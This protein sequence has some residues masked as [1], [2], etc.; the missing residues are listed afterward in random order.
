MMKTAL[1]LCYSM[2]RASIPCGRPSWIY[3]RAAALSMSL[4]LAKSVWTMSTKSGPRCVPISTARVECQGGRQT[5]GGAKIPHFFGDPQILAFYTILFTTSLIACE[6][7]IGALLIGFQRIA[8][9]YVLAGIYGLNGLRPLRGS[10][11]KSLTAFR[12]LAHT[13]LFRWGTRLSLRCFVF[14]QKSPVL[15]HYCQT[16]SNTG[17]VGRI[18]SN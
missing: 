18:R 7:F 5:P 2:T 4:P 12:A 6:C 17:I 13:V 9:P 10:S 14:G 3:R 8:I 11:F 16:V 15:Y 1:L